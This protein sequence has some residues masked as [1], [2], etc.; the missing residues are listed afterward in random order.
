MPIS[1]RLG[2]GHS[3]IPKATLS[4]ARVASFPPITKRFFGV[5]IPSDRVDGLMERNDH[6]YTK[7]SNRVLRECHN[8]R[9]RVLK[10]D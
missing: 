9:C 7:Q 3:K 10:R 8:R 2:C 1:R 5:T 4:A 6:A